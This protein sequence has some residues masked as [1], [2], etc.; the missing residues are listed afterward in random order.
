M[1]SLTQILS[2]NPNFNSLNYIVENNFKFK[3]NRNTAQNAGG[4]IFDKI[5]NIYSTYRTAE[6]CANTTISVKDIIS[7]MVNR[8][9]AHKYTED[10]ISHIMGRITYELEKRNCP[11][12]LE[13]DEY[14]DAYYM[15][16]DVYKGSWE[17]PAQEL[18]D[19]TYSKMAYA[20]NCETCD[21]SF[22][23]DVVFEMIYIDNEYYTICIRNITDDDIWAYL[24][25][26]LK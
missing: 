24:I 16:Y 12:Q 17:D 7:K 8:N 22:D 14:I 9:Y 2:K 21:L 20:N 13:K 19:K 18:I 6:R 23:A 11:L 1:K 3:I 25:I 15:L 5:Y 4:D 26:K 10:M